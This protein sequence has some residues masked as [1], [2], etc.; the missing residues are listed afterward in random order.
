[1]SGR[2]SFGPL[3]LWLFLTAAPVVLTI[4]FS[5]QTGQQSGGLSMELA[6]WLLSLLHLSLSSENLLLFGHFLRK[7][8]HFFLYFTLGAGLAGLLSRQERYP[9]F[10]AAVLLSA[11]YAATDECH[12]LFVMGRGPSLQDVLLDSCGGAAGC[13]CVLLLFSWLRARRE[14]KKS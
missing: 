4:F 10:P 1:M 6:Q 7:A 9:V 13:A 2:R 12:Q 8:A 14:K 11:L 5:G 3:P